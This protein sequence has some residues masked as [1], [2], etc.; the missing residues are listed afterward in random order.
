[1]LQVTN[2]NCQ[3][4]ED[5]AETQQLE[6][7]DSSEVLAS[8]TVSDL[9]IEDISPL[10][11]ALITAVASEDAIMRRR[12]DLGCRGLYPILLLWLLGGGCGCGL[13]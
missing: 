2:V 7:I 5:V 8:T 9:A 6:E 10:D 3:A 1:M 4:I 11:T 12:R 13:C